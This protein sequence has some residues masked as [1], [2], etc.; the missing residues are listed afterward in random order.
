MDGRF[1]SESG[2]FTSDSAQRGV[3]GSETKELHQRDAWHA[4]AQ[5][6][7]L[8]PPVLGATGRAADVENSLGRQL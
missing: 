7:S 8:G 2:R 6:G 3:V 4:T 1:L 5:A